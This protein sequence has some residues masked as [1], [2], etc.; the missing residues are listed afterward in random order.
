MKN[1]DWFG[2]VSIMFILLIVGVFIYLTIDAV[3]FDHKAKETCNPYTLLGTSYDRSV[4]ICNSEN[5]EPIAK[6]VK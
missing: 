4:V 2:I 1:Y 6:K 5:N 3:N